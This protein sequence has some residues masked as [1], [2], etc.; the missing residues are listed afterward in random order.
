MHSE[1]YLIRSFWKWKCF[2]HLFCIDKIQQPFLKTNIISLCLPAAF[3]FLFVKWILKLFHAGEWMYKWFGKSINWILLGNSVEM[4]GKC[5]LIMWTVWLCRGACAFVSA[6]CIH[7]SI[8][9]YCF[10]ICLNIC[11]YICN[12]D[13]WIYKSTKFP[14]RYSWLQKQVIQCEKSFPLS[15]LS[16]A[17]W[18][19]LHQPRRLKIKLFAKSQQNAGA[20]HIRCATTHYSTFSSSSSSSGAVC[21]GN[22]VSRWTSSAV[23]LIMKIL[24]CAMQCNCALYLPSSLKL[25]AYLADD[26]VPMTR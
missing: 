8:C 1:S 18:Y 15:I 14:C 23:Q 24:V 21:V 6:A 22:S 2:S 10:Y 12:S 20:T 16:L 17:T 13:A 25:V 5:G 11:L 9:V 4:L 7:K 19:Q 3:S 26:L